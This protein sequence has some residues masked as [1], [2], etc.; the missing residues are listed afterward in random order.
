M[1][2]W[3]C[4]AT[5]HLLDPYHPWKD[6]IQEEKGVP[7]GRTGGVFHALLCRIV[8]DL[9]ETPSSK[10]VAQDPDPDFKGL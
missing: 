7:K 10:Q 5:F 4:C 3:D 9:K 6:K 1:Y 2:F 8:M